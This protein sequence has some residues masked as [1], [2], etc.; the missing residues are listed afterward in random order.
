MV[1]DQNL[2]NRF[3]GAFN[4]EDFHAIK[5][6]LYDLKLFTEEELKEFG[7]PCCYCGKEVPKERRWLHISYNTC[8]EHCESEATASPF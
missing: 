4:T 7:E 8:S 3:K 6:L 2:K 5:R 1:L